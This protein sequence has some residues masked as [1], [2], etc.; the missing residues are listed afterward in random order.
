MTWR[1]ATPS[2]FIIRLSTKK[3]NRIGV[4]Y[5]QESMWHQLQRPAYYFIYWSEADRHNQ[6]VVTLG[7][8]TRMDLYRL[9]ADCDCNYT[10]FQRL[11]IDL[12]TQ[13]RCTAPWFF[14]AKM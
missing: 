2:I 6:M 8:V 1:M 5:E 3:V 11:S 9:L 14:C 12:S 4:R 7:F 10:Y 13:P